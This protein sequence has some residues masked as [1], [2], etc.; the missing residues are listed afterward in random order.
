MAY[1]PSSEFIQQMK[2]DIASRC[3]SD[4]IVCTVYDLFE[5]FAKLKSY[6]VKMLCKRGRI[7]AFLD[8]NDPQANLVKQTLHNRPYYI[9]S[10][11][12]ELVKKTGI[13]NRLKSFIGPSYL[14]NDVH[15]VQVGRYVGPLDRAPKDNPEYV[16]GSTY[17]SDEI[18]VWFDRGVN[19]ATL[20]TFAAQHVF[21]VS[22]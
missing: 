17:Y 6:H 2:D 3:G 14:W 20:S 8:P 16:F 19:S 21:C 11:P 13:K 15:T 9:D 4:L 22:K 7:M 18:A 12:K 10:T 1:Q 5:N